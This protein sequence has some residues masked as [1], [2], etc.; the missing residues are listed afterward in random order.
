MICIRAGAA[1]L[2]LFCLAI[3]GA[4]AQA[5]DFGYGYSSAYCVHLQPSPILDLPSSTEMRAEVE[6]R[7]A[8]AVDASYA[9]PTIYSRSPRYFWAL[10][11]KVSCGM[12]IGFFK[13]REIN[14]E[15]ISKCDCHYN[16]MLQYSH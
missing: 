1:I 6:Q 13:G 15:T 5:A 7:Y 10:E 3:A 12:A 14:E 8:D 2:L 16:R 11:A 4:T 9:Q